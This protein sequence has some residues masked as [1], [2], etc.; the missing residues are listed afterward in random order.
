[1]KIISLSKNDQHQFSKQPCASLEFVEAHGIKGDAHCG[2]T[3]QHL[4]HVKKD[5]TQPNLRQV[6]IIHRELL[7]ELKK[8][9]FKVEAGSLGENVLTQGIDLLSLPKNTRLQLG[10]QVILKVT[11]LRNPC[12]QLDKYQQGLMKAVLDKDRDGNIIRKSGIMAVVEKGGTVFVNDP[13]EV[14]LP[15]LPHETLDK[16]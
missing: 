5:P 9:G 13:I 15:D 10:N 2:K 8:Q 1:M 12:S 4:S 16:V 14:R 7:D 3:V 6:H 11:G